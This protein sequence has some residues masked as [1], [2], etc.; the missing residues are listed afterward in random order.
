MCIRDRTTSSQNS[1]KV[2]V[3][4]EGFV[5]SSTLFISSSN[6]LNTPG[7]KII[8]INSLSENLDVRTV[9]DNVALLTT[10][11]NHGVAEGEKIT[12]DVNPNDSTTTTTFNVTSAVY[13]EVTVEIP[14][15]ATVLS[16]GGIGRFE[17]LN[18]GA[19]Y[20]PNEY[21]DVALSGGTGS[22][23]KAKIVVSSAGVVNEITI[24]DKGTG[25]KKYDILTVGDSDLVKTN[26]NTPSL[27][28]EVDHACLL[29]TSPSPRDRTRSRM[30]SSA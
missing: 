6:L 11:S 15:V 12:V 19:D 1:V 7:S 26:V 8:S 25:Y 13:Q 27:K 24:T 9:Q 23:A 3:T 2:K 18:G 30:P 5:I 17:I 22:G 29:Y 21:L 20:T 28:I 14:V 10:G 4:Q 16:D